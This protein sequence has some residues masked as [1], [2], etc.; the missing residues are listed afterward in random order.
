MNI[1][2]YMQAT[3]ETLKR[4]RQIITGILGVAECDQRNESHFVNQIGADGIDV[5]L[6]N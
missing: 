4:V 5:V 1:L 3:E 6:C 2:N